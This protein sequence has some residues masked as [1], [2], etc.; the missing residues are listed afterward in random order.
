MSSA[1]KLSQN[2]VR[3]SPYQA[4]AAILILTMTLFLAAVFFLIAAGSQAVLR[5]FE[6]R[7]QVN[8]FYKQ[9]VVP[10]PQD[11]ELIKTKM[12]ATGKIDTF[13]Y[14]SKEAALDI[15]KQLNK[16]DP[17]L[18][19]AVTAGMLPASIEISAKDPKDLKSLAEAMSH[20]PGI[21]DVRFAED[22]VSSLSVWTRSVRLI[23]AGLVGAHIIISFVII[24]LIIGIKVS[25][26]RDEIYLHQLLG[27]THGFIMGPFIWEGVS[28][29]LISGFI[30]WGLAYLIILYSTPFLVTF[31]AGLPVLPVPVWFMLLVLLG[32]ESLGMII[33]ALGA[34]LATW[35]YLRS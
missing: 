27:A 26:R 2:R 19:E 3:R 12:L 18:L 17:L 14:V 34:M 30:A 35:R 20:E 23:G 9:D 32:T 7:P 11:V 24:L 8:A 29:G 31:L 33:G 10:T 1:F 22:I 25:A 15:Y 4:V 13:K 6:T 16:N 21:D 5:Y 28:Y